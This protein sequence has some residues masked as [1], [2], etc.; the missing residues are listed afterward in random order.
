MVWLVYRWCRLCGWRGTCYVYEALSF[1]LPVCR[2]CKGLLKRGFTPNQV[3]ALA[4]GNG[5]G[6]Y[7]KH[8]FY[9]K[10]KAS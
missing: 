6:S 7:H 1:N 2:D 3:K 8:G 10:P 5:E 4:F 9:N